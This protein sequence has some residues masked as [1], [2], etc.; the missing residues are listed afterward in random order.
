MKTE[1]FV[2][3]AND[4]VPNNER[5]PVVIYRGVLDGEGDPAAERFEETFEEHGWPPQ[6]R[7]GVFDYHHYHSTAHEAL[8]VAK[9]TARL[10]LGGPGGREVDVAAGDALVLP[11]GTGHRCIEASGDYLVVGS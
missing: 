7:D 5:L 1:H 11:T 10:M 2:L 3:R 4:W 6:W 9:G 8:G